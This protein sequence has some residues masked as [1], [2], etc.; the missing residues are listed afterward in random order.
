MPQQGEWVKKGWVF[1]STEDIVNAANSGTLPGKMM[2]TVHPQRWTNKPLPW[3][4]ELLL[5]KAKNEVKRFIVKKP[6]IGGRIS[7]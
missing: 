4:K 3:L 5:Q 2:I 1:H 7:R 6:A